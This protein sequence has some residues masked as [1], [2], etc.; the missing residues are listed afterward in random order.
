MPYSANTFDDILRQHLAI[1]NPN[2]ILDVG[3]GAGKN[4]NLI[5]NSGYSGILDCLE[6]TESYVTEFNLSTIYNTIYPYS[7][8][9]FVDHVPK[10]QYDLVIFGD[11]LEH[12]FR[13]KVIDYLDYFL[14]KSKWIIVIW[15][16]NMSQDNWGNNPYEIH[17][18]NFKI[19]DLTQKFD[20]NFY[21][22]KFLSYNNN[23]SEY[24]DVYLNYAIIKG[25]LT[26]IHNSI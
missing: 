2:S 17:K 26:P 12:V 8:E 14:Y 22:K 9:N 24:T 10:F 1:I 4:G 13:S 3:A 18:S 25:Y 7:I 16:N 6:P 19:D 20:V 5:R 11:V 23:H 15:P 21:F